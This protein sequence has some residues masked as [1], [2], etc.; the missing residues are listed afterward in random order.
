M[1]KYEEALANLGL[2]LPEPA[3][4][5]ANFVPYVI[6]GNLVYTSGQ[7]PLREGQV[8]FVG[9]LGADFS[10][11]EGQE[12]ARICAL[13]VLSLIR[14]ACDGD[15]NRVVRCVRLGGFVN[16]TPDFTDQPKVMNGASD[17]IV[18]VFG[19]RGRHARAAVGVNTLPLGVAVEVDAI[20]EI[21]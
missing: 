7:I 13:H 9:K 20:F 6:T 17:L 15:L 16:S 10:V 18:R 5:V 11:E 12:A 4:P 14:H 3:V 1:N 2:T 8:S 21:A 19:E